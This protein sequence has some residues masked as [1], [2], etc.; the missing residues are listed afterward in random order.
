VA[1]IQVI[2]DDGTLEAE[3]DCTGGHVAAGVDANGD[4][5]WD[6]SLTPRHQRGFL[7]DLAPEPGCATRE[8]RRALAVGAAALLARIARDEPDVVR[9]ALDRILP[10]VTSH[11][12]T[13]G[14][15][16]KPGRLAVTV[17]TW[18]DG[19]AACA[20]VSID[21]LSGEEVRAALQAIGTVAVDP[22][23]PDGEA[24]VASIARGAADLLLALGDRY[25]VAM[26]EA[27]SRLQPLAARHG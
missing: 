23:D 12:A 6:L 14:S 24:L 4:L 15:G 26:A 19:R 9:R 13:A 10:V 7:A 2:A 25:P 27:V 22:A 8:D 21:G 5:S 18:P 3:L 20:N 16:Q 17:R 11:R 1:K